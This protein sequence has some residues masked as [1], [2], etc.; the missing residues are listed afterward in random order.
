MH[1]NIKP[2]GT[3]YWDRSLKDEND[4]VFCSSIY[5]SSKFEFWSNLKGETGKNLHLPL[6]GLYILW[7]LE[8]VPTQI[9][10]S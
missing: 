5:F 6:Q 4:L 10:L 8:S 3:V 2:L 7:F 1:K 9:Q